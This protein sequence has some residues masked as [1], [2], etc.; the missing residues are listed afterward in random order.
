M[1]HRLA[2]RAETDLDEIWRVAHRYAYLTFRCSFSVRVGD[3]KHRNATRNWKGR[4][5]IRRRTD[6][7]TLPLFCPS[8]VDRVGGSVLFERSA[9]L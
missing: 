5:G 7:S 9:A 2:P 3:E 4:G 6:T 1:A 8:Q